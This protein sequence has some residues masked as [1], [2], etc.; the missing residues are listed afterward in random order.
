MGRW[1]DTS[2]YR[3]T[4]FACVTVLTGAGVLMAGGNGFNRAQADT[5]STDAE[6][7]EYEFGLLVDAPGVEDTFYACSSCHSERIIAQQ[8]LTRSDWDELID[9]MIEDQGMYELDDEERTIILDYL[10]A[11]YN[12]D[13]PNFPN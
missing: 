12:T 5:S 4:F 2:S 3:R 11:N 7:E 9:W 1:F 10:A 13:R 6:E 8:G